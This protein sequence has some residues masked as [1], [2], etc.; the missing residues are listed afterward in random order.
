[1]VAILSMKNGFTETQ[2]GIIF[3]VERSLENGISYTSSIS[4][5]ASTFFVTDDYVEDLFFS[6]QKIMVRTR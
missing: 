6:Y 2:L 1:M 5:A 3:Q 4:D